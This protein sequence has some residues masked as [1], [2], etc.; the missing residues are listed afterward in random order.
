MSREDFA[1]P[2]L[3]P[4]LRQALVAGCTAVETYVADRVVEKLGPVIRQTPPPARLL[5][6]QMTV[7]DW[8]DIEATYERKAWGLRQILEGHIREMASPAPSSIGILFSL[9]GEEKLWQRVDNQRGVSRGNSESKLEEIYKRRNKITH[10]G[11]RVGRQRA[12]ISS[13]EVEEDLD[14]LE[15]IVSAMHSVT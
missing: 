9:V 2:A 15:S 8:L 7:R 3:R 6:V 4:L 11:D 5:A 14:E 12:A 10:V 1:E 13:M